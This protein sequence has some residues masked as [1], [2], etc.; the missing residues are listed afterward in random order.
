MAQLSEEEF[1][2]LL[3]NWRRSVRPSLEQIRDSEEELLMIL[4]DQEQMERAIIFMSAVIGRKG[5]NMTS[6]TTN[7]G[8]AG[9]AVTGGTSYGDIAGNLQQNINTDVSKALA[10]IEQ[11]RQKLLASPELDEAQKQD[12]DVAIQDVNAELQ[13]APDQRN[14]SRVRMAMNMLASTAKLVDGAQHLYDSVAP[15]IM[16]FIHHL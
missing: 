8:A 7:I 1:Q 3:G 5:F 15:H 11:L 6:N 12:S 10:D 9:V 13:K 14:P 2:S 16:S 4:T